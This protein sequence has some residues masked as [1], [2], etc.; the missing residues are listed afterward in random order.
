L[1]AVFHGSARLG[2][3]RCAVRGSGVIVERRMRAV[4]LATCTITAR[5][6]HLSGIHIQYSGL[7]GLMP[8][9]HL[10]LRRGVFVMVSREHDAG[11]AL[12]VL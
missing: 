2:D 10:R 6:D 9:G 1:G 11:A 5:R 4:S 3:P 8:G 7:A 12:L